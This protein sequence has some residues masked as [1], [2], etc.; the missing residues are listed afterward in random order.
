M[1]VC[2]QCGRALTHNEIGAHRKLI[3]RGA[4][5][6]YCLSCLAAYLGV[7]QGQIEEKIRQF[8]RQGCTLFV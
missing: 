2:M 6:F 7:T 8:K 1:A 4:T 3:N 5:E